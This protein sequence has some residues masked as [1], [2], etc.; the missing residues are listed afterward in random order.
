M[1]L[2]IRLSNYSGI[3]FLK[4]G[5]TLWYNFGC[6]LTTAFFEFALSGPCFLLLTID[7]K[8]CFP[9]NFLLK[10]ESPLSTSA[11]SIRLQLALEFFPADMYLSNSLYSS[12]DRFVL[13]L[14]IGSW[15]F[16]LP[17]TK[18]LCPNLAIDLTLLQ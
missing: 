6:S 9:V 2:D 11:T 17:E 5:L 14:H 7:I 3:E 13:V 1:Q 15:T 18:N 10:E 8:D 12:K 4:F 16:L